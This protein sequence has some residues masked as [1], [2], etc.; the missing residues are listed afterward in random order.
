M[1]ATAATARLTTAE[2]MLLL[3]LYSWSRECGGCVGGLGEEWAHFST[4][5]HDP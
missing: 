2:A 5:A 1:D 3:I 4:C